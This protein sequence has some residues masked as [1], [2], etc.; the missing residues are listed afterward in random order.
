MDEDTSKGTSAK[1]VCQVKDI[2]FE[3]EVFMLYNTQEDHQ[4]Q[5]DDENGD[6]SSQIA[7]QSLLVGGEETSECDPPTDP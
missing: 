5:A 2:L 4:G 7:F 3:L 1:E 6:S